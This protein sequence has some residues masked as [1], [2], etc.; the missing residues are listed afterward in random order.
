LAWLQDARSHALAGDVQLQ[1][2]R[3]PGR[4]M[5]VQTHDCTFS[6]F[7]IHVTNFNIDS[8]RCFQ[9]SL[10]PSSATKKNVATKAMGKLVSTRF[11]CEDRPACL[12]IP[13]LCRQLGTMVSTDR[14]S[15]LEQLAHN[16]SVPEVTIL[17]ST[18]T[19]ASAAAEPFVHRLHLAVFSLLRLASLFRFT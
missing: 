11:S 5:E 2:I 9:L 19:K 7:K 4:E 1:G 3:V 8:H 16:S 17:V 13:H 18:S 12:L 6:C 15:K 14:S 10:M